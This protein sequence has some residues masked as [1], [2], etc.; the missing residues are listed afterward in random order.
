[1][2]NKQTFAWTPD[3]LCVFQWHIL[4]VSL[5]EETLKRLPSIMWLQ[6]GFEN[7]ALTPALVSSSS[8]A[9]VGPRGPEHILK[10]MN[11]TRRLIRENTEFTSIGRKTFK[12]PMRI[13]VNAQA[14]SMH[15]NLIVKLHTIFFS[16]LQVKSCCRTQTHEAVAVHLF[17]ESSV[18]LQPGPAL[19]SHLFAWSL[20]ILSVSSVRSDPN[21]P[22]HFLW[23]SSDT[24]EENQSGY[25][26]DYE[27]DLSL[28]DNNSSKSSFLS[29]HQTLDE[30]KP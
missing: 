12:R 4:Y 24:K 25:V 21:S 3:Q 23:P 17:I 11:G 10:H 29:D 22:L 6:T 7:I 16:P 19:R 5:F 20:F 1:M 26:T 30:P 18:K 14:A 27:P 9:P 8:E 15:L 13:S 28:I 2:I